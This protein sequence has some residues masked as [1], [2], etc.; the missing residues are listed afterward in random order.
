[1]S[2]RHCVWLALLAMAGLMGGCGQAE[3][4]ITVEDVLEEPTRYVGQVITVEG[5]V[6]SIHDPHWFT[7]DAP[8]ALQDEMLVYSPDPYEAVENADVAVTGEV[9]TLVVS[10]FERDWDLDLD[11]ELEVEYA[12]Q[13][14]VVA[15]AVTT[16]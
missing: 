11:P 5:E 1:M 6:A 16:L 12:D 2:R 10:R 14:I 3:A 13:P 15:E 7:I 4:G 9:Q 8:G